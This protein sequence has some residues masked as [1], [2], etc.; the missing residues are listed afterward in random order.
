VNECRDCSWFWYFWGKQD[1]P[2]PDM[3]VY[4][5]KQD[6]YTARHLQVCPDG[7]RELKGRVKERDM[8]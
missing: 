6:K 2:D 8:A 7:E 3:G 1:Y 4:C 5:A